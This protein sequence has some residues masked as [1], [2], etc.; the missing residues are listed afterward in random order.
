MSIPFKITKS[1]SESQ[2][3]N[4]AN[5]TLKDYL[6]KWQTSEPESQAFVILEFDTQHTIR[7]VE[8]GI[9]VIVLS[10]FFVF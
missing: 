9:Y 1:S 7:S 4:S 5:L 3:Y 10:L 6:K 2:V 8:I